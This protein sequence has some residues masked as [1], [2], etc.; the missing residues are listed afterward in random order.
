MAAADQ[1][2]GEQRV[3]LE[4]VSDAA[5]PDPVAGA[6]RAV[7]HHQRLVVQYQQR[8]GEAFQVVDVQCRHRLDRGEQLGAPLAETSADRVAAGEDGEGGHLPLVQVDP[9]Q[10]QDER[11]HRVQLGGLGEALDDR[12][13]HLVGRGE[14]RRGGAPPQV[15]EAGGVA[16]GV[17]RAVEDGL[18]AGRGVGAALDA[19]PGHDGQHRTGTGRRE[20]RDQCRQ[21]RAGGGALLIPG[22]LQR[23]PQGV[24]RG[25]DTGSVAG[26]D[27]LLQ[28]GDQPGKVRGPRV[29]L[30]APLE[31]HRGTL[32]RPAGFDPWPGGPEFPA[33]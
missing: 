27:A 15:G 8:V 25:F 31:D 23:P 30:G 11:V 13:V 2:V 29:A 33:W 19:G 4:V 3:Q 28:L 16:Q 32:S 18:G 5:D 22:L 12:V 17:Q 9:G 26:G 7:E 1:G 10:R 14:V 6:G 24:E 21:A 20:A